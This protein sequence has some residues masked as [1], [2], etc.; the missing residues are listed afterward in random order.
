VGTSCVFSLLPSLSTGPAYGL[1]EAILAA[2]TDKLPDVLAD[3][4][5]KVS[6]CLVDKQDTL[7]KHVTGVQYSGQQGT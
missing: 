5:Q 1:H 6:S 4:G 3:T 7:N 2:G